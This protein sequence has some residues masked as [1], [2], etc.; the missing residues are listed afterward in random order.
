MEK[1]KNKTLR[2]FT[3]VEL[4]IVTIIIAI[5]I[6]LLMPA[7][8]RVRDETLRR[9]CANNLRQIYVAL[10][11][12]A[13]DNN[14][15]LPKDGGGLSWGDY[16]YPNYIDNEKVFNCPA[17]KDTWEVSA[18]APDYW[19]NNDATLYDA[20]NTLLVGCYDEAH[21]GYENKV[22]IDG[23]MYFLPRYVAP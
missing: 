20:P 17:H 9:K 10:I 11:S 21:N 12:Y 7:S 23:N 19:Y 22:T 3:M 5:L 1:R 18:H 15:R 14:G 8:L 2:G 6:G 16:L 4:L 13:Q